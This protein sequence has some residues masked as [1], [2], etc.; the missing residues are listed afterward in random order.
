MS[1]KSITSNSSAQDTNETTT[2]L[3][4]SRAAVGGAA[5]DAKNKEGFTPLRMACQDGHVEAAR[6]LLEKGADVNVADKQGQTSLMQACHKGHVEAAQLLLERG[7]DRSAVLPGA[8][9]AL[10]IVELGNTTEE[11]KAQLRALFA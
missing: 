8:G 4:Q 7:A 11:A 9:T 5:V 1:K 2:K 3:L 10:E 6:L